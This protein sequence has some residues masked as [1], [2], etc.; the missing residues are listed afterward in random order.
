MSDRVEPVTPVFAYLAACFYLDNRPRTLSEV[1]TDKVVVIDFSEKA[2]ALRIFACCVWQSGLGSDAP[3]FLF[4]NI[5][6]REDDV[7]ELV[8]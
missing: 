6:K 3:H 8:I 5:A 7:A 2:D 4:G 1:A